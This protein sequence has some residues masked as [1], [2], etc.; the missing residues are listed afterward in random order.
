LKKT[1]RIIEIIISSVKPFQL[2]IGKIIGTSLAGILQF[3]LGCN[4]AFLD[5]CCFGIFGVNAGPTAK[6]PP[7]L[8]QQ[9]QHEF[10]AAARCISSYGTCL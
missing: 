2:M 6:V 8:M 3:Y 1:N 4:W 7:E 9:A 10:A 5:V